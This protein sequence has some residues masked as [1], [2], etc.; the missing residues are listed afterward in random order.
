MRLKKSFGQHLLVSE[1]VLRKIAQELRIDSD[2]CL[3]EI[4]GGTGNL[5]KILLEYPLRKLYVIELDKDMVEKLN[6]IEDERVVILNEDASEFDFCRLGKELKVAGN[7]PYNVASLI[8]ENTIY[9]KDCIPL[10][11]YM[12]Q[13]E[14]AEKLEGKK[15]TSWLSVFVRSFYDVEYIMTVPPRFFVP[16]PKVN[17]ALIKLIRNEKI[18]VED[19][20]A[21]K[22]LLTK[23]FQHR[24]KVLRKKIDKTLLEK[25]EIDPDTRVE[26]LSLKDFLKLYSVSNYLS[27]ENS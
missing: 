19:L 20:K 5:T 18:K 14:V 11:V 8:I 24:R 26:N 9:H 7:L 25:A 4:G 3:V 16:P 6:T 22:K 1:G 21:Y 27:S 12:V 10:A 2:D 23:L 15:D 17:S 13:K